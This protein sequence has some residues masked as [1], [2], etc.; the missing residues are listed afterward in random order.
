[1][2]YLPYLCLFVYIVVST[3]SCVVFL[4]CF[5]SSC[6]PYIARFSGFSIFY[7]LFCLTF[8]SNR[9]K[10][11]FVPSRDPYLNVSYITK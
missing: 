2:S 1:M 4:F 7:C 6:T 3:T 5:S 9:I 8:I 10:P 11:L